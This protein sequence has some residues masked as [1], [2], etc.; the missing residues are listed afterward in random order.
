VLN[1]I[2]YRDQT[3]TSTETRKQEEP[4]QTFNAVIKEIIDTE[5]DFINDLGVLF[6]VHMRP[7]LLTVK[8]FYNPMLNQKVATAQELGPIFANIKDIEA[9]N[10]VL[11]RELEAM[12]QP[13]DEIGQIFL[14]YSDYLKMYTNYCT[15]QETQTR[16]LKNMEK[17]NKAFASFLKEAKKNPKCRQLAIDSFLFLPIQRKHIDL[18][19][20]LYY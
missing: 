8:V 2:F 1:L 15:N 12:K 13:S 18:S 17:R 7:I 16:E 10:T 6:E 11:L 9:V 19:H 3:N 14:K 20:S 4:K 5:K